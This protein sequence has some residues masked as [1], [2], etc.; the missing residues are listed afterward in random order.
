MDNYCNIIN[1]DIDN[2]KKLIEMLAAQI[3]DLQ[4]SVIELKRSNIELTQSLLNVIDAMADKT[5]NT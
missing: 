4:S 5:N 1:K 3:K 2:H